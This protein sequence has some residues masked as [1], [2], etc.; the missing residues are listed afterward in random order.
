MTKKINDHF[1]KV[2][3]GMTQMERLYFS[4]R[5]KAKNPKN[6]SEFNK[7][8]E[9]FEDHFKVDASAVKIATPKK[10]KA[11]KAKAEKEADTSAE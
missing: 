3:Q 7:V 6:A 1:L 8:V 11:T 5:V 4:A 2:L 9:D 10:A